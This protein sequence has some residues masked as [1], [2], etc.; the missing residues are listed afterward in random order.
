M[1]RCGIETIANLDMIANRR[2]NSKCFDIK[3]MSYHEN[4]QS[5]CSVECSGLYG[6][7]SIGASAKRTITIWRCS[8]KYGRAKNFSRFA[9]AATVDWNSPRGDGPISKNWLKSEH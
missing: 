7:S 4:V 5:G 9:I 2:V 8:N 1:T 6:G 3:G